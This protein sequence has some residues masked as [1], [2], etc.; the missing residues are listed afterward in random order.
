[1]RRLRIKAAAGLLAAVSCVIFGVVS[2]LDASAAPTVNG[3]GSSFAA[4]ELQEWDSQI[5]GAPYNLGINYTS[6][7]SGDGRTS[8]AN[9]LYQFGA[10]DIIYQ[11]NEDGQALV[12]QVNTAH[13][14]QYVTVT[15]GGLGFMYNLTINGQQ[16]TNLQ[17]TRDDV[18]EIF[19]GEVTQWSQFAQ[20]GPPADA[21][22]AQLASDPTADAI[23]PVV[24][25]DAAGES[26]VLSQYC[27]AVDPADWTV[28]QQFEVANGAQWGYNDPNMGAGLPVS[29]WPSNLYK[30]YQDVEASGAD[31]VADYV[32]SASSGA[33]TITYDAAGYAKVRNWPM[34]SVQNAANQFTQP[35]PDAAQAALAYAEGNQLGTF[36]LDFTGPDP[37]AYFPSTYSYVLAPTTLDPT[38]SVTLSEYLCYAVGQG[39]NY[40][41]Q[42]AYAPLSQQVTALSVAAIEKMPGA[43][44]QASCGVGGPAPNVGFVAPPTPPVTVP[45][46]PPPTIASP[47]S[48][49]T[50]TVP[51]SP[52]TGAGATAPGSPT[53]PPAGSPTTV[54]PGGHSSAPGAT[55]TTTCIPAAST[56]TTSTSS[57]SSTSSTRPTTEGG[58]TTTSTTVPCQTA[59]TSSL[60][61]GATVP[62]GAAGSGA[63]AGGSSGVTYGGAFNPKAPT[64]GATPDA[65]AAQNA[66]SK[67]GPTNFEALWWLLI[68]AAICFLLTTVVGSKR[69]QA[70]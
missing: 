63:A 10:S 29:T 23:H 36:N 57:T 7:S 39:Q 8:Y 46:A 66:V 44:P 21:Q 53:T 30:G 38:D 6:T 67:N 13:P 61:P 35:T 3:G 49:A 52:T 50:T 26:Y 32:T 20:N 51:G 55:P 60:A 18:C 9:G 28:F 16:I 43:P 58:S 41:E 33:G 27:E 59:T 56:T 47:T 48:N 42:L 70:L 34:A 2:P 65:L 17:L 22:L 31:G 45:G 25:S 5:A 12:N 24:R 4:L 68:G 62:A 54:A 14:F 1:V 64:S 15:A 40:A 37:T 11:A 19:T 69:K